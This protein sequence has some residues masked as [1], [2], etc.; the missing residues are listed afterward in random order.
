MKGED[1]RWGGS[2][3][4]ETCKVLPH[5]STSLVCALP[6]GIAYRY[7]PC[8]AIP[9]MYQALGT[10]RGVAPT[11]PRGQKKRDGPRKKKSS[12]A[13]IRV[14][15][16]HHP[17]ATAHT[18]AL[19][20]TR[21]PVKVPGPSKGRQLGARGQQLGKAPDSTRGEGV[22]L[23]K[24]RV[25]LSPRVLGMLGRAAGQTEMQRCGTS[26]QGRVTRPGRR[27][28]RFVGCSRQGNRKG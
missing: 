21:T 22:D 20:E 2:L 28:L 9:A 16:H 3:R 18:P 15:R 17:L 23:P 8:R 13:P 14:C 11:T 7:L 4:D 10:N 24:R 26:F 25:V 19:Q 6:S 5:A 12:Q 1:G 27:P